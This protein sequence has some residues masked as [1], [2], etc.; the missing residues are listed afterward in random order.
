MIN[1]KDRTHCLCMCDYADMEDKN[2][3][4]KISPSGKEGGGLQAIGAGGDRNWNLRD[5]SQ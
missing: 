4:V 1:G 3:G 5:G 2:R